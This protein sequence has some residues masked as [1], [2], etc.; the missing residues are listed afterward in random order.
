MLLVKNY[1]ELRSRATTRLYYRS[2]GWKKKPVVLRKLEQL[3]NGLV[4]S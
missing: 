4:V 2:Q 3:I 1:E